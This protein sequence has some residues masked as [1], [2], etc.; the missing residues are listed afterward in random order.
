MWKK[1]IILLDGCDS[2]NTYNETLE[3]FGT[4]IMGLYFMQ[5]FHWNT[6]G[7]GLLWNRQ[8]LIVGSYNVQNLRH[9]LQL[10]IIEMRLDKIILNLGLT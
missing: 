1:I 7:I 6:P 4:Q 3:L 10:G 9:Q 5:A 8:F 2:N